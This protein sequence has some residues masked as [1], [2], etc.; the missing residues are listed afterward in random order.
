MLRI[1]IIGCGKIADQHLWAVRRID[2]CQVVAACDRELLMAQQ[3]AE[4]F[5]IP[6][7]FE[8][9]QHMLQAVKPDVVHIT[10]PPQSHFSLGRACLDSGCH[11]YL[12]KP[13]TVTAGEAE[14]LVRL[15]QS[16][17]L[18]LTAGHNLQFTLE[19]LRMREQVR[20]G[21]VGTPVH[22]ESYF[23]YSLDDTSYVGPLLGSRSH[24][25]R[26]LPGQLFHNIISHGVARIAE[27]L[28][29]ELVELTA[30]AHQSEKL[31]AMGGQEVLD[32]LRVTMR[33]AR[34]T[35]AF[36]CFSTQIRPGISELIV[37]GRKGSLTVDQTTGS[38]V[39]HKPAP[40]KS[41][42][43]YFVPPLFTALEHLRNAGTNV[44]DF[45]RRRL[46]QDAGM[47]ELIEQFYSTV[48]TGG[49][50]PL[51]YRE[52]LLTARIMDQIFAQVYPA[53][54]EMPLQGA[55]I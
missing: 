1:A 23:S 33:D 9:A 15:A 14:T 16:R 45:F 5:E 34:G 47:K 50:P 4:R 7:A 43:T 54:D 52:I 39:L 49:E 12:E 19:M 24:W 38:L 36:F 30:D 32:E 26:Q 22:V 11:V 28:D 27:F 2:G 53:R 18:T 29:D 48:R 55:A 8:D 21:F 46:Y 51:P 3:L 35:T 20:K 41:Y 37:R 6:E 10:T 40:N 13:F 44:A 25:V 17:G 31:K 42:L